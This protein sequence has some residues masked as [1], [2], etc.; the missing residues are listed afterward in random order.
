MTKDSARGWT[1]AGLCIS[2]FGIPLV[3][4]ASRMLTPDPTAATVVLVREIVILALTGGLVWLVV[5]GEKLPLSSIGLRTAAIWRSLA[6]GLGLAVT[7]FAILVGCLG[8]FAALGIHYGEGQSISRALPVTLL[9]VVRAGISE[10]VLYRG[11]ALERLQSLT[12]SKWIAAATTLVLF[13]AFHY[14]QGLAG[15]FLA[16]ILGAVLTGFYLWKRNLTANMFGHFLV[17]F[18]PNVVL[19][20]FGAVD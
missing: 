13:A 8:A 17:D 5:R 19:P 18:V 3:T 9:A 11:Y 20:L 14:R 16:L 15:I 4:T 1:I 10:E 6:W 7:C 2:L 12:G